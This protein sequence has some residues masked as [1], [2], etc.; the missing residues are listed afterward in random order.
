MLFSRLVDGRWSAPEPPP[1]AMEEGDGEPFFSPDGRRL[2]FLSMRPL[3]PGEEG[4]KENIWFV[5]RV[6]DGWSEPQPVDPVVNE[7]DHHWEVSVS[8]AGTLYFSSSREGT[9]GS[10]D[11]YCS[12]LVE[13]VRQPPENLGP[14]INT[15]G[16]DL[17]PYI[18]PDESYLIFSSTGH[19][20]DPS[21]FAF[22]ISFRSGEGEWLDPLSLADVT[23][24]VEQ[25]LWPY[26]TADGRFM[27]FIGSGDIW[28][29]RA[30]FI[31]EMRPT[32]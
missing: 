1:F 16:T 13:G 5:D 25:P 10:N 27:F 19:G 8:E 3:A 11:L 17:T 22:Y 30:D 26:I 12:R 7:Y 24:G 6:G 29:T 23:G 28:W 9:F 18:A 20:A 32:M 31:E 21:E 2:Y 15:E 14:V 4:G